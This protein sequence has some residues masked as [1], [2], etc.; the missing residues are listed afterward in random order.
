MRYD[1]N[2]LVDS[3]NV[4]NLDTLSRDSALIDERRVLELGDCA[5]S[6]ALL[7]LALFDSGIDLNTALSLLSER[8]DFG[9]HPMHEVADEAI[10]EYLRALRS[11]SALYDRAL[12]TDLFLAALAREGRAVTE[13]D[14]LPSDSHDSSVGY[15]RN[16]LSDEAYDVLA[17][18][19]SRP[20]A[21]YYKSLRE[22]AD[23]LSTGEVGYCLL[24]IM[25]RGGARIHAVADII[26]RND[27]KINAVTPVF[28]S[29]GDADVKYA[30][31]SRHFTHHRVLPGDDRY[32]ELRVSLT[33]SA[34]SEVI[35]VTD[36]FGLSV[37]RA[38]TVT[39]YDGDSDTSHLSLVLRSLDG[40]FSGILT[41]LSLFTPDAVAVGIY[42]NLE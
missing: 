36:F 1:G 29:L 9:S 27:F 13:K 6:A 32:L 42:K 38:D 31:I 20:T 3:A 7:T 35:S 39:I 16:A 12:F 23:A 33:G 25:E 17:E 10:I 30:L 2:L 18:E 11:S 34:L 8:L 24:P 40:D 26:Y 21:R 4:D 14:L 37:F 28:G 15:V 22:C 19:L 41:Y 5:D